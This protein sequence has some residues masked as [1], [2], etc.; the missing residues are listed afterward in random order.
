MKQ[1]VCLGISIGI[2]ILII[3]ISINYS[4][5]NKDGFNAGTSLPYNDIITDINNNKQYLQDIKKSLIKIHSIY[6]K[7]GDI[8]QY[9]DAEHIINSSDKKNLKKKF[10]INFLQH[11]QNQEINKLNNNLTQLKGHYS[12]NKNKDKITKGLKSINSGSVLK[13]GY[14]D[15]N[16]YDFIANPKFSLVMNENK[17]SCVGYLPEKNKNTHDEI[18]TVTEVGCDY[19]INV[20]NQKFSYRRIDGNTGFNNALHPD[21]NNY[22]IADYYNLNNY[23]FY[24]VHPY[25]KSSTDVQTVDNKECLT[26]NE[27]GLSIEPCTLKSSQKFLLSDL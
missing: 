5:K 16:D 8:S 4:Y 3:L 2:L 13:V 7:D 26:L 17:Q 24:V 12:K 25:V 19:N 22:K 6:P 23:P 20:E 21:Y 18:E 27:D 15:N 11:L 1:S 9:I 10:N 14:I